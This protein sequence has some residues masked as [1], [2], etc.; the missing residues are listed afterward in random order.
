MC[1]QTYWENGLYSESNYS[2]IWPVHDLLA[3]T[4]SNRDK[5]ENAREHYEMAINMLTESHFAQ[6]E[7]RMTME[8]IVLSTAVVFISLLV[9]NAV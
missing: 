9:G 2:V 3:Q 4:Y 8:S 5:L 1:L 7:V 6:P